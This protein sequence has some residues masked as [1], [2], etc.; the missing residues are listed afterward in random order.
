MAYQSLYR[1]WRPRRSPP[2]WGRSTWRAPLPTRCARS[3]WPTPISSPAPRHREDERRAPL[4]QGARLRGARRRRA[5][6]PLCLLRRYPRRAL[7]GRAGDRRRIQPR[8]R[9]NPRSARARRY[10][11]VNRPVSASTSSTRCIKLTEAAFNALLK[12]LEEPPAHVIFILATTDAHKVPATISSRCQHF[13]FHRINPEGL[14]A[15]LTD[16]AAAEG[17]TIDPA[18]MVQLV[19]AADGS[20]RDAL[21]LL[22][23]AVS[24]RGPRSRRGGPGADA[25]GLVP[26]AMVQEFAGY[27]RERDVAA[28][29]LAP[30]G[31]RTRARICAS[32]TTSCSITCAPCWRPAPRGSRTARA[33]SCPSCS[34][35]SAC[36]LPS[37]L[38]PA[39][40]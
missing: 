34:T 26:E 10:G 23:Q 12:T 36:L 19:Q 31:W 22:D 11:P 21:S 14:R 35:P 39:S 8:H 15:R 4:R 38:A 20:L 7:A 29:V 28:A 18:A 1:K 33:G 5:L 13:T 40:M 25:L 37:T 17:F 3:A 16:V 24:F 2:W 9:R 30:A 27:L 6:R 32:S